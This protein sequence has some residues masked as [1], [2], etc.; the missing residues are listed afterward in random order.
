MSG[1]QVSRLRRLV[2]VVTFCIIG[3]TYET[4]DATEGFFGGISFGHEYA[5]VGYTKELSLKVAPAS[6]VK[7]KDD[8]QESVGAFTML[9]GYRRF[10]SD[11]VYLSGEVEGTLYF[12]ERIRGFLRGTGT[13]DR[14]VWPGRWR[15]EKNHRVGFNARLGYVP[16]AL[17]FLGAGRSVYLLSGVHW[18]DTTFEAAFDNGAGISGRLRKD[19]G[20]IPWLVGIGLEFGSLTNRFD[21]RL[22]YTGYNIDLDR[23]DALTVRSPKL[24]YK[25]DLDE[26]GLY[27]GYTRSFGFGADS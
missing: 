20:V 18:I 9:V 5:D 2:A 27:L 21:V 23:G 7:A 8:T 16:E 4:A 19:Q 26:W 10:L 12:N 22:Q 25:F 17:D 13:G 14:N 3:A 6:S 24:A 1:H 15:L 11:R